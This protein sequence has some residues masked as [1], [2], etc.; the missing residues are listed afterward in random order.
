MTR[1]DLP[2]APITLNDPALW[3]TQAFLAG[4]WTDADDG[5]TR[6]VTDPAAGCP[7]AAPTGR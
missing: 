5:S 3:R 1:T 4:A 7:P 6:D 2:P